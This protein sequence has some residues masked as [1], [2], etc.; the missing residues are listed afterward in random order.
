MKIL[1]FDP[2][3]I[4]FG[5]PPKPSIIAATIVDLPVPLHP[6]IRFK[7]GPGTISA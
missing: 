3:P 5:F 7:F 4:V 1:T 6:I 2:R